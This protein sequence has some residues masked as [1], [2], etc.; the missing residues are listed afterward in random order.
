[1]CYVV[2]KVVHG[3]QAALLDAL[4]NGKIVRGATLYSTLIPDHKDSQMIREV[5]VVYQ[6]DK[7]PNYAFTCASKSILQGLDCR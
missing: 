4:N 7:Y 1:M 3:V 6:E 2:F 5:G